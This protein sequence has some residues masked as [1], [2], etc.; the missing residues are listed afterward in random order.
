MGGKDGCEERLE[1]ITTHLSNELVRGI[2]HSLGYFK[3]RW[4]LQL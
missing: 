3:S 4:L 1:T 2:L